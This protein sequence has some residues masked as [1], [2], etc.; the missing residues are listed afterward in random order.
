M[1]L[2][3]PTLPP[4]SSKYGSCIGFDFNSL[5]HN[6]SKLLAGN[7]MHAAQIGSFVAYVLS[8]CVRRSVLQRLDIGGIGHA[9]DDGSD[10]EL[11]AA[12]S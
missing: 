1:T 4:A 8:R 11:H 3:I 12:V 7:G 6:Q 2:G 10:D 9:P 5:S